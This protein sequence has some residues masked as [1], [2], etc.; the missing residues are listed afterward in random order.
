MSGKARLFLAIALVGVAAPFV[1]AAPLVPWTIPSGST[2]S[3]MYAGG[4]SDNGLFGDPLI[5]G[6]TF[7]FFPQ[8]FRAESVNGVPDTVSDRL[9]FDLWVKNSGDKITEI[10]LDEYGDWGTLTSGTVSASGTLFITDLDNARLPKNSNLTTAPGMPIVS[11]VGASGDWS[12]Y[13][14]IDVA[15]DLVPWQHIKII[16]NNNLQATSAVGSTSFIQ[17]KVGTAGIG[18][19][20]IPEPATLMLLA[21][22]AGLMLRRRR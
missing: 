17:K 4:G 9:E 22:T 16:L 12:G 3:Y 1:V 15:N 2:T 10:R 13:V 11:N 20:V 21:G 19:T 14:Q 7:L 18:I 8:N 6:D 5:V